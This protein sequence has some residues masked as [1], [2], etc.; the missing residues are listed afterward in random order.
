MV[1]FILNKYI[2]RWLLHL[3]KHFQP[4]SNRQLRRFSHYGCSCGLFFVRA[5]G[6][7]GFIFASGRLKEHVIFDL[8]NQMFDRLQYLSHSFYDHASIGHLAIR[9]TSDAKKVSQV[10]SWGLVE[11]VFR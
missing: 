8:R 4:K 1:Y 11:L 6:I 3:W 10:I 9:L 7:G 2:D 5:L